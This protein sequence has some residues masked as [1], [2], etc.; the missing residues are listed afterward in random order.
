MACKY[1][2]D[3]LNIT[4]RVRDKQDTLSPYRTLHG[5]APLARL[6]P[7][8]KPGFHHV[9]RTLTSEPKAEA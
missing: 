3:V 1:A 4:A 7:F 2:C 5:R 6:L 8:L 9:K